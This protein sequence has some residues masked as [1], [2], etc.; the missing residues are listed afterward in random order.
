MDVR[1]EPPYACN[2][3]SEYYEFEVKDARDVRRPNAYAVTLATRISCA[4]GLVI[5]MRGDV[6]VARKDHADMS[7][8]ES[9]AFMNCVR[10]MRDEFEE[11]EC[12]EDDGYEDDCGFGFSLA[13]AELE[14]QLGL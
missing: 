12:R 2:P 13:L 11:I 10:H 14:R 5:P 8:T 3:D 6:V 7:A 4:A 1:G 9:L